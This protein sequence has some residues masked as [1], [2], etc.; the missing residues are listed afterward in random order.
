MQSSRLIEIEKAANLVRQN[1]VCG[2]D[3]GISNIF[4][5]AEKMG[6]KLIRYP[7]G[8]KDILGSAECKG[9]DKII[10]SNSSVILAREIFTIA[11]EIGHHELHLND[12]CHLIKDPDFV[13]RDSREV[14]ANYFAACLLMPEEKARSFVRLEL[15]NKS[16][17]KW[18]ALDIARIQTAFNVSFDMALARLHHISILPQQIVDLLK[19][20]KSRSSVTA[21][22][23]IING[24]TD[25]C[26]QTYA[27]KI[28]A[29]FLEWVLYNYREKLI[30]KQTLERALQYFDSSASDV[31]AGET[32]HQEQHEDLDELISG[33]N[34]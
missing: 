27:K 32:N 16:A 31:I 3:Y 30:P 23:Q 34:L 20:E 22:L 1:C 19:S 15:E 29:E 10:F 25:L 13:E 26:R 2:S 7:I 5:S 12:D 18:D 8:E 33:L 6:Y 24:T 14:E 9:E 28:P 4:E 17:D 11:H 21:L